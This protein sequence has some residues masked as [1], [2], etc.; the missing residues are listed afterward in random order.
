[1]MLR[2]LRITLAFSRM[3]SARLAQTL[4]PEAFFPQETGSSGIRNR[5]PIL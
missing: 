1:M 3:V 2:N 5:I 4:V